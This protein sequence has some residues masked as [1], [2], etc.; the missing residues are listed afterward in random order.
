MDPD[1]DQ[2][3]ITRLWDIAKGL[4][5]KHI[6]GY[7]IGKSLVLTNQG[8]KHKCV[9][10]SANSTT[11]SEDS[12]EFSGDPAKFKDFTAS[13]GEDEVEEIGEDSDEL[14]SL[15]DGVRIEIDYEKFEEFV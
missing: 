14:E 3:E 5:S 7:D 10:D 13:D 2:E 15:K 8:H 6:P 11:N 1:T 4:V 9:Y 12:Q